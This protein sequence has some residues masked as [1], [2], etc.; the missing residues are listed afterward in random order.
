M[1]F[2]NPWV[3]LGDQQQAN[4]KRFA[5]VNG[6]KGGDYICIG[7]ALVSTM[8]PG[9]VDT[10]MSQWMAEWVSNS[11]S[12]ICDSEDNWYLKLRRMGDAILFFQCTDDTTSGV[13]V[14]WSCFCFGL[15]NCGISASDDGHRIL[16][17]IRYTWE[18]LYVL[19]SMLGVSPEWFT[20]GKL[21]SLNSHHDL[22]EGL[23]SQYLP[24][25]D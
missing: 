15:V 19:K 3:E 10:L 6:P 1:H 24:L 7:F 16:L 8:M 4:H 17:E 18:Y 12:R 13:L 25:V 23:T 11:V 20:F 9:S 22:D 21:R 5:T 14:L 2:L